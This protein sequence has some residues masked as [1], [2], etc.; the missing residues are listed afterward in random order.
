MS[1]SR[2]A[3]TLLVVCLVACGLTGCTGEEEPEPAA[4][5]ND[6]CGLISDDVLERLAPG[7]VLSIPETAGSESS[8]SKRCHIDLTTQT[9]TMRGDF[10]VD[11]SVNEG[12]YDDDWKSEKCSERGADPGSDGPGD[13]SCAPVTKWDGGETRFDGWAWVGDDYEAYVYYQ[14]V[15][16][17]TMPSGA[18]QDLRDLLEA[19]V[20]SLPDA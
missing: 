10:G 4:S 14:L 12:L 5:L 15:D 2:G 16:P 17:E 8:G 13:V 9:T 6:P 7:A 1:M 3:Q 19:A 18:E 11:V 20:D